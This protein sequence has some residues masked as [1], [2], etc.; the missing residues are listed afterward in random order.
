TDPIIFTSN[1]QKTPQAEDWGSVLL[2]S[3]DNEVEWVEFRYGG[4]RSKRAFI[5][6]NN[7]YFAN[8]LIENNGAT[9][10]VYATS[11]NLD[12][13]VIQNNAG[14]AIVCNNQC[15][16]T[17]NYIA[18]NTGNAIELDTLLP[19]KISGNFIYKN[20]GYAISNKSVLTVGVTAENNYLRENAGGIYSHRSHEL[21]LFNRNN[22]LKNKEFAIKSDINNQVG[23][24]YPAVGNWF[25]IDT[26]SKTTAGEYFVSADYDTSDFAKDG[27]DFSIDGSGRAARAY[28][29]YISSNNLEE[30]FFSAKVSRAVLFGAETT[31]GALLKYSITLNNR[32]TKTN[33][34][35][36]AISLPADQNLL[37]CSAQPATASFD[38]NLATACSSTLASDISFKNNQL[39]WQPTAI[40][41][42]DEKTLFFVMATKP[43]L[44]ATASLPRI[45]FAGKP[46]SYTLDTAIE[47][48]SSGGAVNATTATTTSPTSTMTSNSNTTSTVSRPVQKSSAA[49]TSSGALATGKVTRQMLNGVLTYL[50]KTDDGRYLVLYN[51]DK[52]KEIDAFT[53]SADKAKSIA[54]FGEFTYK[55]GRAT[56]IKFSRFEIL[57]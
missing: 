47:L 25:G 57:N 43:T 53:R 8:N 15:E 32:T 34:A 14:P 36:M 12:N 22:F 42:V 30:V 35:T 52:W 2:D 50:L 27:N 29:D 33:S 49:V 41:A 46:F 38:Y 48:K 1:N 11:Q 19:T 17:N 18:Q 4:Q 21:N 51:K 39:V 3:R 37:L 55:N 9:V 54:V 26:G 56:A 10:E 24:I 20:T 31:P 45:D 44:N 13:N 7:S 6:V 23:K 5:E 40:P 28:R 16:I